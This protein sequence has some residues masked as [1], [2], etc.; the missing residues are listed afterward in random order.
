MN[1]RTTHPSTQHLIKHIIYDHFPFAS[2]SNR[3]CMGERAI[4]YM[5]FF[6]I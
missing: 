1:F 4:V 3:E 6:N 2:A 5:S